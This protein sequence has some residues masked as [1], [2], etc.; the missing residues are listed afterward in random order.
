MALIKEFQQVPSDTQQL[1]GPVSCGYR[2]FTVGGR[3]VLQLDTYGSP[4]RQIQGKISQ[5]VQLDADSARKLLEIISEAFP[6]L[7]P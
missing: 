4:E 3:R 6:G 1:H 7:T 2:S 5:T